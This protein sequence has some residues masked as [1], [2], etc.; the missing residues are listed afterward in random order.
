MTHKISLRAMR[1]FGFPDVAAAVA[2]Q[3]EQLKQ[4]LERKKIVDALE[5]LPPRPEWSD[6]RESTDPAT[7]YGLAM[8][9]WNELMRERPT[10]FPAPISH[11]DIM[12]AINEHGD[13]DFEV[14]DDTPK[15]PTPDEVL[16]AKKNTL[17]RAVSDAENAALNKVTPPAKRRLFELQQADVQA[18][19][20]TRMQPIAKRQQ[21]AVTQ[22]RAAAMQLQKTPEDASVAATVK[23]LEAEISSLSAKLADPESI[24]AG[25]R[26][27]ED[28]KILDKSA[29]RQQKNNAI[30]RQA[31]QAQSDIEDLTTDNVDAFEIPSFEK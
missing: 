20:A 19:D 16:A 28:Q 4:W 18:A 7:D 21:E 25:A 6:F 31:A 22:Y 23:E 3:A 1:S 9:K 2:H 11:P 29:A 30:A 12:A 10:L 17:F 5:P 15:E 14:I 24:H 8:A 26:P 13:P 27:A